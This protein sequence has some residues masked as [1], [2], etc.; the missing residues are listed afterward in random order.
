[1]PE[2]RWL[3]LSLTMILLLG[4]C[5]DDDGASLSTPTSTAAPTA[6]AVPSQTPEP[7]ST[8]TPVAT[9]TATPSITAT[10]TT[11]PSLTATATASS[12][13]TPTVDAA[14]VAAAGEE[15]FW[16]TLSGVA[17]RQQETIDLLSTAVA[18]A[19]GDGRSFFLL[20][21]MH[22]YR[23]GQN[24]TDY[25]D[26][27]PFARAEA[28]RAQAALDAAVPLSSADRRVPGFRGAAT[29]LRG[30]VL[31]SA[32]VRALGLQQL[33]DAIELYPEFNN[34]SFLGAVAPVVPRTDP[35]FEE[36]LDLV[37]EAIAGGCSPF[38]EPVICGNAGKAPH[39]V[40]GA[41]MIFGDMF[42]KA[43]DAS[44]AITYYS[45]GLNI[46][47]AET[48]PFRQAG[49][50]RLANVADRV[51]RW[52]DEDPDNDPAFIGRGPEACAICHY[53]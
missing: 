49:Q 7:S 36:A 2:R 9:A 53:R 39:N 45:I 41:M 10:A 52:T 37:R 15:A 47:G 29:F 8:S 20:G 18:T 21:M 46:E 25:A 14:A 1:M 27:S 22:L 6:T 50:E 19:P 35:L 31:D 30:V 24:L 48:W 23:V 43:G 5:A 11:T 51:A 40:Q 28:E 13:P 42:A 38:T 3:L 17:N 16:D 12:T 44:A 33:R 34:F 4:G 32:D 26:P